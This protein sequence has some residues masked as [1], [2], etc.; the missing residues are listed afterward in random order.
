MTSGA[1]R[2][3]LSGLGCLLGLV[4]M[5]AGCADRGP[6]NLYSKSL[7]GVNQQG[8]NMAVDSVLNYANIS[9]NESEIVVVLKNIGQHS[10][11]GPIYGVLSSTDSCAS[12]EV[13]GNNQVSATAVFGNRGQEIK[14]GDSVVGEAV[15]GYGDVVS[16]NYSY[17]VAYY[18]PKG[19]FIL[20]AT[21]P[22]GTTWPDGFSF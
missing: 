5:A 21:D 16:P 1:K 4:V 7:F 14:P 6:T 22:F 10:T 3:G 17:V 18:C 2:R 20:T 15:D 19:N 9:G 13:F 8:A 11:Y 12:P